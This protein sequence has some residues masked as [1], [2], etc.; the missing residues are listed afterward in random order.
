MQT[1]FLVSAVL[2]SGL[3][4][5]AGA[6]MLL[7]LLP[8]RPAPTGKDGVRSWLG[9]RGGRSNAPKMN[10]DDEQCHG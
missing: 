5:N 7:R 8:V 10:G 1:G 9:C 3:L 6:G 4:V 2:G